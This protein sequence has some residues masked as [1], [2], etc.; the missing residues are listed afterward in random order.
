MQL[1]D[2]KVFPTD[3]IKHILSFYYG[4]RGHCKICLERFVK[5]TDCFNLVDNKYCSIIHNNT[6]LYDINVSM[7][8]EILYSKGNLIKRKVPS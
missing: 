3:I 7:Y 2:L 8:L 4:Q 6:S 5:N 1:E